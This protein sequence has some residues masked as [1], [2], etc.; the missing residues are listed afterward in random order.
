MKQVREM[1]AA[2]KIRAIIVI[3]PKGE[4]V[5]TVQAYFGARVVVDVWNVGDRAIIKT[6]KAQGV[7]LSAADEW[8]KFAPFAHQQGSAG[9][10]GYDRFT[11]ALAGM[12]ID[13]IKLF[14]HCGQDENSR[15]AL[16][17]YQK[18]S[19][20][21]CG[22]GASPEARQTGEKVL[23]RKRELFRRQGMRLANGGKSLHYMDGLNRLRE[24]GYKIITAI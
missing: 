23:K 7:E 13:G 3:N 1:E 4:H 24:M 11:A 9:G 12:Y 8:E 14:D 18:D 10:G 19:E 17:A 6:A 15:R 16:V 22:E 2:K 21:Y 5:G 20:K